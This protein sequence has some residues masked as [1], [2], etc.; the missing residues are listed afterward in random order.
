MFFR[1]AI[2]S[3]VKKLYLFTALI[4]MKDFNQFMFI[5]SVLSFV[6]RLLAIADIDRIGLDFVFKGYCVL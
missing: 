1:V 6:T 4:G 5:F 3:I 2:I